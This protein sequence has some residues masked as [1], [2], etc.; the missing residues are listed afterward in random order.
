M[1]QRFQPDLRMLKLME[2]FRL[3]TNIC[4]RTGLENDASSL[5]RLSTLSYK[6]LRE[7]QIPSYYKLCA[8][9]KATGI[10]AARKKSIKR[11]HRT[12]NLY[13][14][15][16][17]LTTCYGFRLVD[18][19]LLIPIGL[20]DM[21]T[22][23]LNPHTVEVLAESNVTVR[24]FTLTPKSFS[25]SI[26]KDVEPITRL[27]GLVGVDRN[28]NN[29]TVGNRVKVTYYDMS[30]T[31]VVAETTKSII[32]SFGRNDAR[33]RLALTGKYGERR[34]NRVRQLIHRVSKQAVENAF[35]DKQA[36]VFEDIHEIRRLY[37]KWN[38]QGK[39]Y[40]ARMNDWPF[41]EA[42]RQVEYKAAWVGVPVVTLSRSETGGTSRVC[43]RCGER[44][45]SGKELRRKL[46]CQRCRELFDR[47][48]VAVLNISRRGRF[49]F[50]RSKG[51]GF[52]AMVQEPD[53]GTWPKVILKVD[54][55]K[56]THRHESAN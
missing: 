48:L 44:L 31:A 5:K 45:Q 28:L 50:E 9:S 42:K 53:A 49:T 52:E 16:P 20:S 13:L 51:V 32:R 12:R 54:P 37:R 4:I 18:Q 36:I 23:P 7:F 14:R 43:P 40:R 22:V 35:R 38:W 19:K 33:I 39:G 29:L 11:G 1:K 2:S 46:W 25:L 34:K 3:M 27:T 6:Q 26:R 55:T 41:H 24:S 15:K 47:D 10:L 56:L 17:L 21:A 8:I 30:K